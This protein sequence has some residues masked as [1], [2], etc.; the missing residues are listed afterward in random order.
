MWHYFSIL[1]KSVGDK[2]SFGDKYCVTALQVI[3]PEIEIA[4]QQTPFWYLCGLDPFPL[5]SLCPLYSFSLEC[6]STHLNPAYPS[7]SS[8]MVSF[9]WSW[10]FSLFL[11]LLLLSLQ[12]CPTLCNPID[13]SPP[14]SPV[15]GILQTRTLEWVAISFSISF[16][17]EF[18]F[19]FISYSSSR[20]YIS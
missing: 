18:L 2:N 17:N 14:G 1:H 7:R 3:M 9:Q 19:V 16:S 13:G 12:L 11:L 8:S 15:P 6:L 20:W 5:N 10:M 4:R